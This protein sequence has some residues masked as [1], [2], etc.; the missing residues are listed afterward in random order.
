[1]SDPALKPLTPAQ[2]AQWVATLHAVEYH[3]PDLSGD[4]LGAGLWIAYAALALFWFRVG[5]QRRT[6]R[7][8]VTAR[9]RIAHERIGALVLAYT[10]TRYF[11][12]GKE[13]E[14]PR[15]RIFAEPV[16]QA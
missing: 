10:H 15:A 2:Q 14:R 16:A 6:L 4:L 3:E 9:E 8:L 13:P 12:N 11:G 5:A 1:M 7:W